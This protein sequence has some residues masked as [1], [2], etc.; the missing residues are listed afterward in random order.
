MKNRLSD[1][2]G[3]L[4]RR[5]PE[6]EVVEVSLLLPGWQASALESAAFDRGLTAAEMVRS[7]L[8]DFLAERGLGVEAERPLALAAH[9]H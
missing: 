2:A 5:G 7:L 6:D 1:P 3:D 9:R 4:C 8:R